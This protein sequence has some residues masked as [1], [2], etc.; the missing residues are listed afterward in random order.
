MVFEI[1]FYENHEKTRKKANIQNYEEIM[2]KTMNWEK[3]IIKPILLKE[4]AY[5]LSA[6]KISRKIVG[7]RKWNLT[8]L[9]AADCGVVE[10]KIWKIKPTKICIFCEPPFQYNLSD[11]KIIFQK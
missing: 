6:T 10:R 7:D 3:I 2:K 4:Y 5:K 9:A 8:F 11:I 1:Y